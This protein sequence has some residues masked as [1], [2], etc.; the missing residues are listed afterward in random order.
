[1]LKTLSPAAADLELRTLSPSNPS[2]DNELIAFVAALTSR[3]RQR[4]DY[5]L[6]QAW[7]AVFLRLHGELV[8]QDEDLIAA[9]REWKAEQ[10][11]EAVR[12]GG[13]MG[14]CSSVVGFLRSGG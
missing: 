9:L 6:L 3:L 8:A 10:E 2:G 11:S 12:L 5:E 1:M 7:M 13:L 14:Y 4:Q